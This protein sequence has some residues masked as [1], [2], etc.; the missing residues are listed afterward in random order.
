VQPW[1]GVPT[2]EC[3]LVDQSGAINLVFL[4]RRD[5]PGI[6]PGARL[7]AE[8]MIGRHGGRLAVINPMYEILMASDQEAAGG[9][10]A[11]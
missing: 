1:A 10:T 3:T 4:G 9:I 6:G 11:S 2:L 5:V 8:G 7:S